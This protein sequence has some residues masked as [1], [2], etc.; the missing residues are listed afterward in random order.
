LWRKLLRDPP[1]PQ[2]ACVL[3]H[4][5]LRSIGPHSIIKGVSQT[6]V[7]INIW[8]PPLHGFLKVN[9]DGPSKGNTGLA[10]FGGVIRDE[11]CQIKEIFHCHLGK[12]T[13]NMVELITLEQCL[14]ILVDSNSHNV[15]IEA[16]L[17]LIIR[18]VKKICNGTSL[19]KVSKDWRLL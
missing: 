7:D 3:L 19:D 14:E 9:I 6:N 4:L 15:I 2:D 1:L 18:V 5:G 16:D 13:N 10:D 17:E 8:K 11:K 12:A